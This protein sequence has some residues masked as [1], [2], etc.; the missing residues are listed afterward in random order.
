MACIQQRTCDECGQN[1]SVDVH[2]F[3]GT[4]P[5]C[6]AKIA[7]RERREHLAGLKGLTPEERLERIE[8]ALYDLNTGERLSRLESV[9]RTCA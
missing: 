8:A 3:K 7:D 5:E 4:C 9:N 1:R 2:T 6:R